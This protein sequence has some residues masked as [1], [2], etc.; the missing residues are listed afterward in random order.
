LQA[1]QSQLQQ[2]EQSYQLGEIFEVP[3]FRV[4]RLNFKFL[5]PATRDKEV[6]RMLLV[7]IKARK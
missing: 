3:H 6:S 5:N 1:E 4:T 2:L 7:E